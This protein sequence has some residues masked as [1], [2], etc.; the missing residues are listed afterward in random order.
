[1]AALRQQEIEV[2]PEVAQAII[3]DPYEHDYRLV[4]IPAPDGHPRFRY[5]DTT[6]DM[7]G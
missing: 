2:I 6:D 7:E 1:M 5:D 3:D 4:H